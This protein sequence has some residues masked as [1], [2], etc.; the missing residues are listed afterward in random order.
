MMPAK[1][2]GVA[3]SLTSFL[4]SDK[5]VRH[6]TRSN[7]HRQLPRQAKILLRVRKGKAEMRSRAASLRTMR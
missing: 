6:A 3:A 1:I 5:R 2:G 4:A 7:T